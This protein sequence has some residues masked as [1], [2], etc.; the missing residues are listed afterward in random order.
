MTAALLD[1]CLH[2]RKR[3]DAVE[4]TLGTHEARLT[5]HDARLVSH[6]ADI[7]VLNRKLDGLTESNRRI[8]VVLERILNLMTER[9]VP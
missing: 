6:E 5:A 9:K 8:E 4:Q 7:A 1:E 2:C 3:L